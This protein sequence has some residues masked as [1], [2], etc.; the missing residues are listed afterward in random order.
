MTGF[1][2]T[3]F[4]F[5]GSKL[6]DVQR[7]VWTTETECISE[8]KHAVEQYK[9]QSKRANYKCQQIIEDR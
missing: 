9:R 3:L 5:Y 8:G 6:I 7:T 1:L 4:I 2:L